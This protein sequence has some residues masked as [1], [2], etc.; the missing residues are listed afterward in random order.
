MN[1]ELDLY[2]KILFLELRPWSNSGFSDAKYVELKLLIKNE[3]Y[4]FQ[5]LYQVDFPKP[6]TAKRKYYHSLIENEAK[7]YLNDFHQDISAALNDQEKLY[8]INNALTKLLAQ[9]LYETSQVIKDHQ[10]LFSNIAPAKSTINPGISDD[11]YTI[12]FLKYQ[13][14]RLYLEIQE[15]YTGFLKDDPISEADIH[16]LYFSELAPEKSLISKA[17]PVNTK[18]PE[19]KLIVQKNAAPFTVLKGDFREPAKG[20]LD[21]NT[22]IKDGQRFAQFEEQLF[23]QG[24]I[25]ENYCFTN[26]FGLKEEMAKIYH[27]LIVK[28]YFNKRRFQPPKPIL[29]LDIRKFLDH[30]YQASLDKQFRFYN[31]AVDKITDYISKHRWLDILPPC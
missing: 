26:K 12:Q 4:A 17:V 15:S 27:I 18:L 23:S 22:I 19:G 14:I 21:Y 30:R 24:F 5:P 29:H 8:L 13:L 11:S 3:F 10:F 25:N 1:N 7:R 6:L 31:K 20:I 16:E 9:K 2:H 28:N